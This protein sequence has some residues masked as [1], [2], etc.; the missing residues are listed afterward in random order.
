M[1][2]NLKMPLSLLRGD[3]LFVLVAIEVYCLGFTLC[4]LS[5]N[6]LLPGSLHPFPDS[7]PDIM[8]NPSSIA[9]FSIS[10]S[11]ADCFSVGI[12]FGI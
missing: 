4:S 9:F 5:L 10:I 12:L 6:D 7:F 8:G 1:S 2:E 11:T 3:S